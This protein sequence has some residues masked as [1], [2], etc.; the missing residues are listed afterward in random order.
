[1]V[2]SGQSL[3][4][5]SE[6]VQRALLMKSKLFLRVSTLVTLSGVLIF[7]SAC[8]K[9]NSSVENETP[10]PSATVSPAATAAPAVSVSPSL[11]PALTPLSTASPFADV[12]VRLRDLEARM[13]S[14][15]RNT[16]RNVG[17]WFGQGTYASSVDLRE[18]RDKY[19][20]RVY[21]PSGKTSNVN[22]AIENGA[23]H[24]T[25]NNQRTV[26]G[27]NETEHYEQIIDFPKP[28]LAEKMQVKRKQ[29]M[30]VITVPKASPSAPAVASASNFSS[31][32]PVS[33]SAAWENQ[34][35]NDFDQMQENMEQAWQNAFPHDFVNNTSASQLASAVNVEDQKDKYVVHFYLPD[36][37]LSNV[38]VKFNNGRLELTAQ[39][40][41]AA[42]TQ[43]AKGTEQSSIKSKYEEMI[44]LPGPVKDNEMKVDHKPGAVIVTLPKA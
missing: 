9:S 11:S 28:V 33:N 12:N 44:T 16:F 25:A 8:S 31:A 43:S 39:E 10:T 18:Q 41:K 29:N 23:L 27:T 1:M 36:R 5:Q 26:N 2:C 30:V 24:I 35:L 22:A 19:V 42:K 7:S 17:N 15:F 32:S 3:R 38:N 6:A 34:M 21:V 4:W 14:I 13:D 40:H 20:A 37:D